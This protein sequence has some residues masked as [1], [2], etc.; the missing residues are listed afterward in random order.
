MEASR[1]LAAATA[2]TTIVLPDSGAT[3]MHM[4]WQSLDTCPAPLLAAVRR[5]R[6]LLSSFALVFVF[7]GCK[8]EWVPDGDFSSFLVLLP[9][10]ED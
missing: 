1:L 9:L 8:A 2:R 10:K 4:W 7:D 5:R 3:R 6:A